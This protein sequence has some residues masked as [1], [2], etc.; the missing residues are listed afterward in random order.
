MLKFCDLWQTE[1]IF[2]F[3]PK[4]EA[5]DEFIEHADLIL[6]GTVW[7]DNCRSWYKQNTDDSSKLLLWP[8]SGL[9]FIEALSEIRTNDYN[10]KYSGNR[11]AWLGNGFS[12]TE[13]SPHGDRA[14]Y[15]REF[16]DSPYLSKA[17]RRQRSIPKED[18]RL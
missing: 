2:S 3:S 8:G 16:D 7:M 10:I 5:V 15:I 13:M 18:V 4:K 9:H 1:N 17:K 11:F 14:F 6:R 12:Q